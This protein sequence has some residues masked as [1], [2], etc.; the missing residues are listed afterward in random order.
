MPVSPKKKEDLDKRFKELGI[1]KKDI[2]E[3]F[4]RSSGPGG[5][6]LNKVSTCV[7]LKHIP[8]GI[9]V[10]CQAER[11]QALNRFLAKRKLVEKLEK[12]I[13]NKKTEAEKR[14]WKIRKQKKK[15]SRRA[16]EE[17]LSEKKMVSAKKRL[18][19]ITKSD[20]EG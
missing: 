16:K 7:V 17:I 3:K 4:I 11:S 20:C 5:Q 8:T 19:K 10:K 9:E 18:R 13:L 14:M 6:R 15:R 2:T 1:K 12:E